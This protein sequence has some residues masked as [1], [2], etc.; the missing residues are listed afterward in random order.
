MAPSR[1]VYQIG[2]LTVPPGE[3]ALVFHPADAPDAPRD[4]TGTSDGRRLSFALGAWSWSVRG[5]RP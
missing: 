1:R 4:V 3:H 2:P 5:E